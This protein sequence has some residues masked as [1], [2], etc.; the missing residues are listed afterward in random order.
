MGASH[1]HGHSLQ[2]VFSSIAPSLSESPP[3][4]TSVL[5]VSF[6]EHFLYHS[7]D[8]NATHQYLFSHPLTWEM[9]TEDRITIVI[10][11]HELSSCM[12][13]QTQNKEKKRVQEI[14]TNCTIREQRED[15]TIEENDDWDD[16]GTNELGLM[17]QNVVSELK[18]VEN[19]QSKN[20]GMR[21][22][23]K[24]RFVKTPSGTHVHEFGPFTA[25]QFADWAEN[26]LCDTQKDYDKR[27]D[28]S[29]I[30]KTDGD[31]CTIILSSINLCS[32]KPTIVVPK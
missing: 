20:R 29:L 14:E 25:Q 2:F 21:L 28:A 31:K 23:K 4:V 3:V 17:E 9:G 22:M 13:Q 18:M 26:G 27:F 6:T 11:D 10:E 7:T 16:W 32:P 12:I 19:E 24:S 15:D 5:S 1:S 30:L 8:S